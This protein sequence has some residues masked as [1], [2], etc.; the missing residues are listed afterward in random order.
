LKLGELR[1]DAEGGSDAV[2]VDATLSSRDVNIGLPG[3]RQ[4]ILAA[5]EEKSLELAPR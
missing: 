3:I 5:I 2:P 4:E 1:S